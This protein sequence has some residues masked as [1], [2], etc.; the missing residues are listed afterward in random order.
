MN[1]NKLKSLGFRIGANAVRFITKDYDEISCKAGEILTN[2]SSV[3]EGG[4]LTTKKLNG[5]C[6]LL[7]ETLDKVYY[8]DKLLFINAK[9][10][11]HG[12]DSGEIIVNNPFILMV[13]LQ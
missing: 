4:E 1:L 5:L 9:N 7:L 11:I 10:Y 2:V 6:F 3:W 12:T 8:Y 13:E